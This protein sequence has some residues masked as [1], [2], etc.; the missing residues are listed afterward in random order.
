MKKARSP[1]SGELLK[2][3]VARASGSISEHQQISVNLIVLLLCARYAQLVMPES[4][5]GEDVT[6]LGTVGVLGTFAALNL[7]GVS[8][9]ANVADAMF[10]IHIGEKDAATVQMGRKRTL[11]PLSAWCFSATTVRGA[12][13]SSCRA[14][15]YLPLPGAA[16][17]AGRC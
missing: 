14:C 4:A 8:E 17:C 9:S 5:G 12:R 6:M 7:L 11:M 10:L 15:C 2:K 16:S 3:E 1:P 13:A